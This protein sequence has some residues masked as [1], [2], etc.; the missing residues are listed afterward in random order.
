MSNEFSEL[1]NTPTLTFE[2][3][4]PAQQA[5]AATAV[6]EASAPADAQLSENVLTEEEKKMVD[7]FSQKIDVRNSGAVLQYGAGSQK[8]MADFSEKALENVRTK[9][10]GEVGNMIAGLVTEL[11]SFDVSEDEKGFLGLFKKQGNK[12]AALKAKYDKAE[13]N[14][15]KICKTLEDH[16]AQLIKDI[17]VLDKMYDLNLNYFKELTMY[18]LAGKQ[19]LNEVREG[20]LKDLIAKA[21]ESGQPEDAQAAKDLEAL[22]LRFEKKIHD[23]E[24]TRMIAV[25]TAPQIRLVQDQIKKLKKFILNRYAQ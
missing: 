11:Q 24:L 5:E 22:C 8:K 17:A 23:L 18:I 7:E 14:V 1:P 21:Q 19:R 2:E 16:Q 25:Q 20:E 9:D 10:M 13:V 4:A 6:M 12:I 15:D 3:A